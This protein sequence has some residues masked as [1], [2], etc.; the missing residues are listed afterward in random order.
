MLEHNIPDETA[1]D[2][3]AAALEWVTRLSKA[4]A[5]GLVA[6]V[7]AQLA[8][9]ELSAQTITSSFGAPATAVRPTTPLVGLG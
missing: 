3:K 8:N 2:F 7:K 9:D 6:Q 4:A 5:L 1:R